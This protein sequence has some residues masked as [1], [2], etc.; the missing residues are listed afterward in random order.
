MSALDLFASALGAFILL[1]I[2]MLPYFGKTGDT[3]FD[4]NATQQR[5]AAAQGNT[6]LLKRQNAAMQQQNTEL[7][8]Q[9]ADV[10]DELKTLQAKNGG[11]QSP[12]IQFPSLDLVV[13]IDTTG[14]MGD[15]IASLKSEIN[16]FSHAMEVLSDLPRMAII[17][18]KDSYYIPANV[19]PGGLIAVDAAGASVLSTFAG[20]LS[21]GGGPNN[22]MAENLAGAVVAATQLAWS[23][24]AE[25]HVIVVLSDNLMYPQERAKGLSAARAFAAQGNGYS[26]SGAYFKT[27]GSDSTDIEELSRAGQGLFIDAGGSF[28]LTMLMALSK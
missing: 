8:Q 14:S 24:S 15:P 19:S 28:S 23:P 16:Q 11:G 20:S 26:V 12:L 3:I 9:L 10:L 21:A 22:E 4:V 25:R 27:P 7:E 1:A 17:E 6:D 18:F 13:V 2:I 5:I